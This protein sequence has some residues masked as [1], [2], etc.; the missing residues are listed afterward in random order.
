MVLFILP[1]YLI[2]SCV[3]TYKR[4]CFESVFLIIVVILKYLNIMNYFNFT[5]IRYIL[6]CS[7]LIA[8]TPIYMIF[9]YSYKQ[10][11]DRVYLVT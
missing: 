5:Y 3:E 7:S 11:N 8:S 2:T 4:Y 1:H 9:V 10:G 6:S